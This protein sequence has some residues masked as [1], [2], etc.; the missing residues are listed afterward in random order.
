MNSIVEHEIVHLGRVMRAST[1]QCAPQT[2]LV[3]YWR[4]RLNTLLGAEG[5]ATYQQ[6]T[7]LGM[8]EELLEIEKVL[9]RLR[10]ERIREAG[11]GAPC[12]EH[13]ASSW[14]MTTEP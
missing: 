11:G 1:I 3:D 6:Y 9:R 5:L 2:M 8:L 12:E 10:S 7:L 14:E 4:N 13:A